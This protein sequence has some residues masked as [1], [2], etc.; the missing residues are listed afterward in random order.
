MAVESVYLDYDLIK[1]YYESC[2]R[3]DPN[4]CPTGITHNFC[5]SR[6]DELLKIL[7]EKLI[8]FYTKTINIHLINSH[9]VVKNKNEILNFA[10]SNHKIAVI[11][12]DTLLL[13][14]FDTKMID[15]FLVNQYFSL[16]RAL[17][18][19]LG[20]CSLL[21][22]NNNTSK[23]EY[24]NDKCKIDEKSYNKNISQCLSS[25]L[26][27]IHLKNKLEVFD[28]GC[29]NLSMLDMII[30]HV[31]SLNFN[32]L[33]Y[34]GFDSDLDLLQHNQTILFEKGY[35]KHEEKFIKNHNNLIV[36]VYMQKLDVNLLPELIKKNVY[37]QCDLLV[38]SSFADLMEP[39][40]F[41]RL[42]K[43]ICKK[44][45]YLPITFS[46][47]THIQYS[48]KNNS[49]LPDPEFIT[50][51]YHNYLTTNEQQYIDADLL[52]QSLSDIG[53]NVRY[54]DSHWNIKTDD[55][56]HKWIVDFITCGTAIELLRNKYDIELWLKTMS[57]KQILIEN[58]DI[59]AYL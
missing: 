13:E 8:I 35:T 56:I 3:Y 6:I 9:I 41:S 59:F 5:F 47:K 40:H 30:N 24:L 7:N 37:E 44:F 22:L 2:D 11:T 57:K 51:A 19:A 49:N 26:S 16:D 23:T 12:S 18:S 17:L 48:T 1:F 38:A 42:L 55:G 52:V 36:D 21:K 28:L 43:Q 50:N 39:K 15:I 20:C 58:I 27:D 46:G 10:N 33:I 54:D 4:V 53:F 29:G 45:V 34:R 32:A 25:A 31:E 14:S